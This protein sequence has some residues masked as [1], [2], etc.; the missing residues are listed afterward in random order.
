MSIFI[1]NAS[2]AEKQN[3]KIKQEPIAKF[4]NWE[5][6]WQSNNEIIIRDASRQ[7]Q[8]YAKMVWR[9]YE[10]IQLILVGRKKQLFSVEDFEDFCMAVSKAENEMLITKG[11]FVY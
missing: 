5:I 2:S 6:S 10:K 4:G 1:A 9:K 11:S 7:N 3:S 8:F